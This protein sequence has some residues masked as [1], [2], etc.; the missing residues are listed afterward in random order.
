[1]S[2]ALEVTTYDP[3]NFCFP[4]GV[5]RESEE[6]RLREEEY[7]PERQTPASF[8]W[9]DL[10]IEEIADILQDCSVSA[11]DGYDAEPIS[12]SSVQ[13]AVELVRRLP[14]GIQIPTVVP[15]PDGDIALEWRTRD[16]TLFS[17]SVTGPT[18][19]YAGRFGGSSRQYGEEPFFG[20]IPQTILGILARYF[21]AC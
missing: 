9:K 5:S 10:L 12:D 4:M 13:S 21:S 3:T 19:V 16:N 2:T 6:I 11:W 14:E 8:A 15:E 1:M 20:A 7:R 18:L 17:L